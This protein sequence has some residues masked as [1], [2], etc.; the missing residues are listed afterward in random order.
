MREVKPAGGIQL[1]PTG[2]VTGSVGAA[3]SDG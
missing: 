2:P 1:S 3:G